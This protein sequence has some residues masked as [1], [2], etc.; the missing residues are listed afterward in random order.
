MR[1]EQKRKAEDAKS[2]RGIVHESD[3]H[4]RTGHGQDEIGKLMHHD[5]QELLSLWEGMALG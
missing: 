2:I 1:R 3:K 5:E 4:K